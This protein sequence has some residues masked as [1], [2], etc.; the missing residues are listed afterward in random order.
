MQV[1]LMVASSRMQDTEETYG[2]W[3]VVKLQKQKKTKIHT[4]KTKI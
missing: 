4:T 2:W 3:V 1:L